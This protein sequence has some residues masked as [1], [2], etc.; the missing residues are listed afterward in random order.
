MRVTETL[1]F[2]QYWADPR[3][4]AKRPVRNGSSKMLVG[5][6]IYCRD[7][8]SSEW[9]QAD[10][11]HS[12]PDGSPNV[13]NLTHDT[14]IDRILVSDHYFYFGIRAPTVPSRILEKMQY[15]NVRNYRVFD[16]DT[17]D[18][19]IRWLETNHGDSVNLVIG[20]PFDF[21]RSVSRYS[22]HDNKIR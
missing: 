10:S 2:D 19:L 4:R 13:Y 9:R 16:G 5:D 14:D 18:P 7:P 3:F 22:A 6:N 21:E 15:S 20:D 17:A 8:T 1:S 12:N 11:H